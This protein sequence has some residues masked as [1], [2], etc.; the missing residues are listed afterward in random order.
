VYRVDTDEQAQ[1]KIDALPA[2]ALPFFAELR[3]LL[4]CWR[5]I[6]GAVTR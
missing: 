2:E 5:S 1:Q 6:R 4:P 3:T